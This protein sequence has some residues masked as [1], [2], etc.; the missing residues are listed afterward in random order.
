[1]N[2]RKVFMKRS[3]ILL[4]LLLAVVFTL[5][6]F[7]F[8]IAD[9]GLV[10]AFV[11]RCYQVI[12][13]RSPDEGGLNDWTNALSSGKKNAAE[14]IL[15]FFSSNE[16]KA[17]GY[18]ND[19]QIE[20][21]YKAMLNRSSDAEG[22]LYWLN[23]MNSGDT[24]RQVIAGFCG[25]TEF[26]KLCAQYGILPG[27]VSAGGSSSGGK[28]VDIDKIREF[29]T[30]CYKVILNRAP[31]NNGL[32]DWT[33]Q[34]A[35]GKK[36]ASEIIDGFISSN[37]Y[38]ARGYGY[39]QL[40]ETL[41]NAMLGRA[42]DAGGKAYWLNKMKAGSS[43][44]EIINGF[45][46][47]TEFK[48]LCNQYGINP[49]S[50]KITGNEVKFASVNIQKITA[51]VTRCYQVI[52]GREPE[53]D[54]LNFWVNH[55]ASGNKT[56][57]EIIHGF[58]TS[59]EYKNK[60]LS[61]S[62][63]VETLYR[64]MLGRA[65][66]AGGKAY[67]LRKLDNGSTVTAIING[68]CGS[69]EFGKLC[70]EYGITPGSVADDG[71]FTPSPTVSNNDKPA[72]LKRMNGK[73]YYIRSD[74]S[75]HTGWLDVDGKQYYF[76]SEGVMQTDWQK[77]GGIWFFFNDNGVYQ[78]QGP[79]IGQNTLVDLTSKIDINKEFVAW[80]T[81]PGTNVNYPVVKSD[82][83]DYYMDYNFEGQRS[84][85][86]TLISLGKCNWKTH[87]KNIVIYGHHVEGSG[88]RM[89]K[90][91]LKYKTQSYFNDHQYIYLDSLYMNGKYRIFAVFD[92]LEGTLDPSITTFG[93]N[94]EF[95]DFVNKAKSMSFY[96]TGVTVKET[97]KII[98]LVTC[99]RYYK[100]KKGRLIVMAVR[101]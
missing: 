58:I 73:W 4:A 8:A 15:G 3:R 63:V 72:G 100:P 47:S 39:D 91:L 7:S 29:V 16:F 77:I 90:A 22:K 99:D 44:R 76:N 101:Q 98:T 96:N 41:Y 61:D 80:M 5:Q 75:R 38:R 17:K 84:K 46:G 95:M 54:G 9:D 78:K 26:R 53:T 25:S 57:S 1:M 13:G 23:K 24:Y 34:L 37:E 21:L 40:I 36:N 12:L 74:G 92:M 42:S 30:R 60:N 89:F 55:L 65:S 6:G 83:I 19:Q 64:A 66:D 33:S 14:I 11:E 10:R 97:D 67:W 68:F 56:A 85:D 88:D 69:I 82:N 81:I 20:L 79:L 32:E 49:G 50:V 31:D 87:S 45:C 18:N 93:S 2:E 59:N 28:V 70:S 35:T 27:T 94:K 62:D 48:K 71:T 43:Y 52:L 86:G 51:F